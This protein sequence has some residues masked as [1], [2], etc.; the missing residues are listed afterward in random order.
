[1]VISLDI[2]S[3]LGSIF[4]SLLSF[5]L[6]RSYSQDFRRDFLDFKTELENY[7]NKD[8]RV[9]ILSLA[10]NNKIT[11]DDFSKKLSNYFNKLNIT[12]ELAKE[13]FFIKNQ[14]KWINF[15]FIGSIILTLIDY[16]DIIIIN[17]NLTKIATWIFFI[18][19]LYL[20]YIYL[21]WEKLDNYMNRFKLGYSIS[22]IIEEKFTEEYNEEK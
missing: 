12:N 10:R 14:I 16:T 20:L 19:I 22:T 4:G 8:M 6:S 17:W 9:R 11:L 7:F 1:M 21:R 3:L 5:V 15:A 13:Y 18:S 2:L